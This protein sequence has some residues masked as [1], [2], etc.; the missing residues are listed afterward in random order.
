[1]S[2]RECGGPCKACRM[3]GPIGRHTRALVA[4]TLPAH[5]LSGDWE[6][7]FGM[8][9][10]QPAGLAAKARAILPAMLGRVNVPDAILDERR[11][12]CAACEHSKASGGR[13]C[14]KLWD[15][16]KTAAPTCGCIIAK[17]T[18]AA[19]QF[20]PV[21]NWGPYQSANLPTKGQ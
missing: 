19:S 5:T 16:L 10:V 20:C 4:A 15:A 2:K 1:M 3:D 9:P 12:I 8:G 7:P 13:T 17:K 14:G 6:C 18:A 11:A 21:G